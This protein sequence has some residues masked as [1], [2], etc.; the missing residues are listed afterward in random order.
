MRHIN[1]DNYYGKLLSYALKRTFIAFD[2]LE[3]HINEMEKLPEISRNVEKFLPIQ[4]K[5]DN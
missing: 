4:S 5:K 3:V 1:Y 2:H